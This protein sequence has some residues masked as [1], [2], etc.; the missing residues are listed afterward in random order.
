MDSTAGLGNVSGV[1]TID[2]GAILDLVQLGTYT[3]GDKFTL[4]A[5]QTATL[6]GTFAGLADGANFTDAGGDWQID[7]F[8]TSPGLNG[9]TGTSFVTVTAVPEPTAALLG[10]LGLLALLRRRRA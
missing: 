8:D 3:G 1:L 5:Y 6:T 2:S 9:G 10:S 4:F 7:Y